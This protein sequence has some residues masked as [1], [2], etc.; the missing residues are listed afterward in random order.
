MSKLSVD[1][2]PRN[3]GV[4]K[5]QPVYKNVS[6]GINEASVRVFE[7]YSVFLSFSQPQMVKQSLWMGGSEHSSRPAF[8]VLQ[9]VAG[10][11]YRLKC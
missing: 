9:A 4:T 5:E 6:K 10:T 11:R 1:S 7:D 8:A 2:E 3:T